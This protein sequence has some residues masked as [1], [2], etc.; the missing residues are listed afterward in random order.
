MIF[1]FCSCIFLR[2]SSPGPR[3]LPHLHISPPHA[4][5]THRK[6]LSAPGLSFFQE[7]KTSS[8]LSFHLIGQDALLTPYLT[9]K[10]IEIKESVWAEQESSLKTQVKSEHWRPGQLEREM[11][12][13][14]GEAANRIYF[15]KLEISF[16]PWLK[17][18]NENSTYFLMT[19]L[20]PLLRQTL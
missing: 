15:K 4:A 3:C 14:F 6:G 18:L 16:A 7:E 17:E 13:E 9:G 11:R 20:Y 12:N 2:L 10:K 1:P 8:Y 19:Y 5:T